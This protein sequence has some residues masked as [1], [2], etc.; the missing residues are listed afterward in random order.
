M[1]LTE[2]AQASNTKAEHLERFMKYLAANGV[3]QRDTEGTY[4]HNA[5]SEALRTDHPKSMR[6]FIMMRNAVIPKAMQELPSFLR[7]EGTTPFNKAFHTDK[8]V[9][10]FAAQD[11]S[12]GTQ[13]NR[14]MLAATQPVLD[15]LTEMYPWQKHG[16][17]AKVVDVGGGIGHVTA[18]VLRRHP[19]FSGVVLDLPATVKNAEDY[20]SKEFT[21]LRQRVT[22]VGGSF[23]ESIPAGG[24]VYILK[25]ILHDWGDDDCSRILT[26]IASAMRQSSSKQSTL[27]IIER[28]YEFSPANT[29]AADQD[30]A[31]FMVHPGGRERNLDEFMRL[32]SAAGLKR[33]SSLS[34]HIHGLEAIIVSLQ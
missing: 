15:A 18:A 29:G 14:A 1:T 30:L 20:W 12:L 10:S 24:D 19:Q 5:L 9:W 23:F 33:D 28:L 34:L 26:Q 2:L 4:R 27:L 13:V 22:F 16:V 7:G 32:L 25:N 21:D 3:F 31:M 11:S 6:P 8:N 17:T